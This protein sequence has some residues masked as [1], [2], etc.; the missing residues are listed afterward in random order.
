MTG[1]AYMPGAT[2]RVLVRERAPDALAPGAPTGAPLPFHSTMPGYAPTLLRSA[3]GIASRLGIA[4]VLVKDESE[5]FG[6]PSFKILGASWAVHRAI[7]DRLGASLEDVRS[8][9]DLAEA[10]R[11]LQPFALSA[12]T[13]GNHGRA[14]AR[15]ATLLGFD[16]HIYVPSQMTQARIDAIAGEGA[17][18][19]VV[20]GGYDD[21][22]R[23]SSE[24]AGERCLVISDTS[25]PGYEDVPRWV[26]EGY[27]TIFLEVEDALAQ[28]GAERPDLVAVQ[29]GVGAL[30]AAAVA[31]FW[32]AAGARPRLVGVEPTT[33]A[34]VLHSVEQGRI[35]ALEG[36][37]QASMMAGLNCETASLV[38]WPLVSRGIDAYMSVDDARLPE[39]MTLLA[40]EGIVA[41]ETGA[42]GLAGMLR[43]ADDGVPSGRRVLGAETRLLLIC[44]EGATDPENYARLT[45]QPST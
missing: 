20:D 11:A 42:A 18:V 15:M 24:I 34:C 6:L 25:W 23:R 14:V 22:V 5:R 10:A 17:D 1:A 41:G 29:I 38:A 45:G 32:G 40:A 30:A 21:A 4:E 43:L 26:I 3:P 9:D 35:V 12:A 16:A 31:H 39:A 37:A 27:S 13:D 2:E 36:D 7:V 19:T 33:A 8:F 44:T 28:R